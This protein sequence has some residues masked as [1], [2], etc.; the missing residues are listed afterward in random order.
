M[1]VLHY[2][3]RTDS[4]GIIRLEIPAGGVGEY[5]LEVVVNRS[6]GQNG[7]ET[8]STP[9]QRGWPPGW[10]EATAGSIQDPAFERGDQGEFEL[11][12]PLG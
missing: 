8:Q 4:A 5:E 3:A 6:P 10:F 7:A 9:E 12:E 1:P 2:T 11:R